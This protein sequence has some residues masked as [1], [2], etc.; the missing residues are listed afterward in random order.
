MAGKIKVKPDNYFCV[1]GW[2]ITELKLKGNALMIYAIIYGFSQTTN[3]AFTGSVDYLCEWLGGVSRPTV[4]NTLDNL[5]QQELL[6]KSSITKGALIYN[7]YIAIRTSKEILSDEEPTSKK[8][9]SVTSK[10]ILLNNNSS[11]NTENTLPT[12]KRGKA[13]YKDVYEREENKYIK[14]ALVKFVSSCRGKNY[15]PKVTTVEKFASTLR[16]NAGEDPLVAMQIVDQSI[17]NSWKDLYPLKKYGKTGGKKATANYR[18]FD[19]QKDELAKDEN[20]N[21]KVY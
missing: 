10:E 6:S 15:T 20:G 19:P 21:V 13:S 1:Q 12:V 2:M 8:T 18:P 4:I 11:N 16:D 3:T 9:L 7:S 5:V 14:E 17:D